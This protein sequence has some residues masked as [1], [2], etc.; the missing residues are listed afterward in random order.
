MLL[1]FVGAE[2]ETHFGWTVGTEIDSVVIKVLI[3][4]FGF[5]LVNIYKQMSKITG[6]ITLFIFIQ[7]S[8]IY[9]TETKVA[10]QDCT[11]VCSADT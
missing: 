5:K 3:L 4:L 9:T 8:T 1:F 10:I 6:I 2:V 11:P 7:K